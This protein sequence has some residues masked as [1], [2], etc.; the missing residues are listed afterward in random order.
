MLHTNHCGYRCLSHHNYVLL[1]RH[2]IGSNS[3]LF[4][5]IGLFKNCEFLDYI[6]TNYITYNLS[7]QG[8]FQLLDYSTIQIMQLFEKYNTRAYFGREAPSMI[9]ANSSETGT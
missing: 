5:S 9:V 8:P 7:D 3:F 4:D 6:I 2:P 1:L